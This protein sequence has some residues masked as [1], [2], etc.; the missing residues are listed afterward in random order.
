MVSMKITLSAAMRA[1]DVSR[2][3][4]EQL[5]EAAV[6]EE[7]RA[8]SEEPRA[9]RREAAPEEAQPRGRRRRRPRAR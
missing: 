9:A 3:R 5:A 6:R 4:P 7:P 8:A 2:P 1:R